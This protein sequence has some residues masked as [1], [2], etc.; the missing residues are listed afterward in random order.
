VGG[1]IEPMIAANPKAS[2]LYLGYLD[3][4]R[5]FHI[6]AIDPITLH[7]ILESNLGA[8][9]GLSMTVS[10]DGETIYLSGYG[11][12]AVAAV[13]ASN[14]KLIGTVPLSD[15]CCAAVSPDSSTLYVAAGNYPDMA[16]TVVDTATFQVTQTVPLVGVSVLF[17]LAFRPTDLSSTCQVRR[18]FKVRTSSR[19]ISPP[20]L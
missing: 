15:Q 8:N 13:Q 19:S 6:Q 7:V 18:I 4:S 9:G 11:Y 12:A 3:S 10:P 5:N 16:V 14:L 17:G 2:V 1:G 20:R